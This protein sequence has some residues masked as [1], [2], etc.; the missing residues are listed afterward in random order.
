MSV[1]FAVH[2]GNFTHCLIH[3]MALNMSVLK[4]PYNVANDE[5]STGQQGGPETKGV[6]LKK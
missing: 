3:T 1:D 2:D 6:L 5:Y 4:Y